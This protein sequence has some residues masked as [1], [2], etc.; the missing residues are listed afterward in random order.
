M[1]CEI[2]VFDPGDLAIATVMDR[3]QAPWV[4]KD[5]NIDLQILNRYASLFMVT[6]V[7]ATD[8]W[9]NFNSHYLYGKLVVSSNK[10]GK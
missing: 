5:L 9:I 3:L 6:K 8:C 7:A 4:C 2:D 1:F 10:S